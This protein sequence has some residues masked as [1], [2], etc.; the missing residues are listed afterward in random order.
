MVMITASFHDIPVDGLKGS[1]HLPQLPEIASRLLSV[2]HGILVSPVLPQLTCESLLLLL[3]GKRKDV[4][5]YLVPSDEQ[6]LELRLSLDGRNPFTMEE[7][8]RAVG[9]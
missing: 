4:L 1:S 5:L 7:V 8:A 6:R 2:R 9:C 3:R